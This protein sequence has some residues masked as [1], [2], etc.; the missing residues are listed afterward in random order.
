MA[1]N[2][3][4]ARSY[5]REHFA[6]IL[7]LA[8]TPNGRKYICPV[9]GQG[10]HK[11]NGLIQGTR[12]RARYM[13]P[14][15]DGF[16]SDPEAGGDI[17]DWASRI[18]GFRQNSR[19]CYLWVFEQAGI[20]VQGFND[21]STPT[22]TSKKENTPAKAPAITA[23]AQTPTEPQADYMEF[24]RQARANVGNTDYFHRRGLDNETIQHFM[25]GYVENWKHPKVED[26]R[27][28]TS[29]RAI[30]PV[31]SSSYLARDT[32][33]D[34]DIPED[35]KGFIKQ[36][37]GD[38][39]KLYNQKSALE[40][41]SHTI[42]VTEGE[43]DAMSIWQAGGNPLGLRSVTNK[44]VLIELIKRH[45]EKK[46]V[47]AL[48]NDKDGQKTSK[49]IAKQ[50]AKAQNENE[51]R[52]YQLYVINLYNRSKDANEILQLNPSFLREMV[53]EAMRNPAGLEYRGTSDAVALR[54]YY[55]DILNPERGRCYP[56]GFRELD[57]E[58]GGGLYAGL[59]TLGAI[60]SLGKTTFILQIENN[61]AKQGQDVLFFSLEMS[62]NE[63][64]AKSI[65][66]FTALKALEK[67]GSTDNAS[68]QRQVMSGYLYKKYTNDQREILFDACK[69]YETI[70]KR[71]YT[72]EGNF[73]YTVQ[74]IQARV[75]KHIKATGKKPVVFVDYLQILGL[76]DEI[77]DKS[78]GRPRNYTDKQKAD[79]IVST[80]KRMS[81]D[82]DVPV[83]VVSSFNR[84]SYTQPVSMASFK[85]SGGIEYSCDV[86]IGLQYMGM[87]YDSE[88][89]GDPDAQGQKKKGNRYKRIMELIAKINEDVKEGR[90]APVQCK[91]LKNRNGAR[92]QSVYF[93][94]FPRYNLYTELGRETQV[95]KE[96]QKLGRDNFDGPAEGTALEWDDEIKRDK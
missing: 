43:L 30:I 12:N 91:L 46:W 67:Y 16:T 35:K 36:K 78:H 3:E 84:E 6:E 7:R 20:S 9:C 73:D 89:D 48:D 57:K 71:I 96:Y 95:F 15:C 79:R 93:Q 39:K 18:N 68:T 87:D 44:D 88:K 42:I 4:E 75:Q 60:S 76:D 80:L 83:V 31:D 61:L 41:P 26:K 77:P 70:S 72:V 74:D 32:R 86:L 29:P 24:F 19:E 11:N 49:E 45:P 54:G 1:M 62:R 23:T 58:L 65:S 64:I 14:A 85:E 53:Q 52:E 69:E 25:L 55:D 56:T 10:A 27:V 28:P 8:K 63:L 50:I 37:V 82:L 22:S 47:L 38:G 34:A 33:K 90:P 17:F 13:C 81:R 5:C 40:H 21:Q 94:F 51:G 66:K 92:G 2:F 59:Y